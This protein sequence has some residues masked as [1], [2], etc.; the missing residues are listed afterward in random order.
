M[1]E[2]IDYPWEV[3]NKMNWRFFPTIFPKTFLHKFSPDG[4]YNLVHVNNTYYDLQIKEVKKLPEGNEVLTKNK[5]KNKILTHILEEFQ[6][7]NKI[8]V[9]YNGELYFSALEWFFKITIIEKNKNFNPAT[10]WD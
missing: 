4:E 9:L 6:K 2:I 3:I 7:R 1:K 10:L 8:I 5:I